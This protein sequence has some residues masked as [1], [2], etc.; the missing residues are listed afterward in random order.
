MAIAAA[1]SV[2]AL[3][4]IGIW[5][6]W[7]AVHAG[8]TLSAENKTLAPLIEQ[9][10]TPF[11]GLDWQSELIA[12]TETTSGSGTAA[13]DADGI[14]NIAGNVTGVLIDSYTTLA[15]SGGYTREQGEAVAEDV[16]ESLRAHVS[17]TAYSGNDL[18]VD[19][20]TSYARMLAYRNDLRIA[21]EP[22]LKNTEAEYATFARYVDTG[23]A[24]YLVQLKNA[25]GNYR[26]AAENA[27]KLTV[28]A[29]ALPHHVGILNSLSEFA[30]MLDAL[31]DH[32]DDPF[33]SVA[34]LR[35][36]NTAEQNVFLSFDAIARYARNKQS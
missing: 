31:A 26:A 25:A 28:P 13:S 27:A 35:T 4:G 15:G 32:G 8:G 22:L 5:Q 9:T 6:I 17:Y 1:L 14:S 20:D 34:L 23:D 18:K 29:D 30:A 33:A 7:G 21:L 3:L 24:K 2:V 10:E 19:A 16:A 11:S 12:G 36:Y